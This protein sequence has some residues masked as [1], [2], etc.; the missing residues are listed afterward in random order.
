MCA[1]HLYNCLISG[2]DMLD[3]CSNQTRTWTPLFEGMQLFAY[4]ATPTFPQHTSNGGHCLCHIYQGSVCSSRVSLFLTRPPVSV[5]EGT[6]S[7]SYLAP[8]PL[9]KTVG[10]GAEGKWWV[11]EGTLPDAA[12][13][14]PHQSLS[15][16]VHSP[17]L[18]WCHTHLSKQLVQRGG[19]GWAGG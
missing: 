13:S 4:L 7:S 3:M 19:V 5:F 2:G 11:G 10:A 9:F 16:R 14:P 12:L 17:C 15:L 8:N 1:V 6:Q 18:T